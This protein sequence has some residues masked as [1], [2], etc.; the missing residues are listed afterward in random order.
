MTDYTEMRFTGFG[1]DVSPD[2]DV[3]LAFGKTFIWDLTKTNPTDEDCAFC[4]R[5]ENLETVNAFDIAMPIA[6]GEIALKGALGMLRPGYMLGVTR[7]HVTSFAQL[8]ESVLTDADDAFTA[9]E[10]RLRQTLRYPG[11]IRLEHGSD[12]ISS[13][14]LGAGACVM[15]AHQHLIPDTG[16]TAQHM[17]EQ[18]PEWT[19][20]DDYNELTDMRGEPYLYVG[21]KG[22]HYV[23]TNPAVRSQWGRRIV[24]AEDGHA[25]W[26]WAL[27]D[28]GIN[29]LQTWLSLGYLPQ[30]RLR[31][32][33]A[34]DQM[35]FET[36]TQTR[37]EL[38]K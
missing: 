23:A 2:I 13:C 28:G 37:G 15:H 16:A 17:V 22:G 4:D 35:L 11:Y 32:S 3:A 29:L 33:I 9:H 38:Y 31:F 14:G 20:L 26:D 24:A 12:N 6:D 36:R 8:P 30:G 7:E 25:E 34:R 27:L 21:H 1:S 10:D 19:R 5:P 18:G